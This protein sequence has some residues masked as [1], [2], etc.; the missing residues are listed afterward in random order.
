MTA[1]SVMFYKGSTG[2]S[3]H[4]VRW[5]TKSR[6]SH[7]ALVFDGAGYDGYDLLVEAIAGS[8]THAQ[9]VRHFNPGYWDRI[10]IPCTPEAFAEVFNWAQG[11][12]GCP[13]DWSGLIWSQVLMLPR[14]HPD[15]WFCSEFCVAGLQKLGMFP[16][17][18]P[19]TFSPGDLYRGL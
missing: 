6:Y 3:G 13:Y 18:E 4:A 19:C 8:R 15:R 10:T 1:V 17:I 2:I 7:C 12:L 14:S 16:G 9:V 11:E 5:W